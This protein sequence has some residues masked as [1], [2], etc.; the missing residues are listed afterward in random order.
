MGSSTSPADPGPYAAGA[1][2]GYSGGGGA[3]MD[4]GWGT[5]GGGAGGS[6]NAGADTEATDYSTST[7]SVTISWGM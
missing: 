2:G 3:A 6:Y 5:T 4:S 1:G 7:G